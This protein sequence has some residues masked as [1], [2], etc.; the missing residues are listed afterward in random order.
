MARRKALSA[1]QIA[2]IAARLR[3]LR[4]GMTLR[5]LEKRSGVSR[6]MISA[7]ERRRTQPSLATMLA[8]QHALELES[9]EE[10][11]GPAPEVQMPSRQLWQQSGSARSGKTLP[12]KST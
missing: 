8:L 10:L 12:A 11:L 5:E 7:L 4:G 6:G 9:L 2:Q 1:R 3:V